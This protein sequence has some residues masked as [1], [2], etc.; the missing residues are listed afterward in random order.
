[1]EKPIKFTKHS[2][3][4]IGK[5]GTT[6]EEVIDAIR[7]GIKEQAKENKLMCRLNLPYNKIWIDAVYPIKQVAPIIVEE[8]TEIIVITVYTYYF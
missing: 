5:R 7:F 2:L 6:Q 3:A 4:R 1:M 8:E